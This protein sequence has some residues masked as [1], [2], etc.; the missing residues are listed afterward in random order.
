M[1]LNNN[2]LLAVQSPYV[3]QSYLHIPQ[4]PNQRGRM[5]F[6]NSS[7]TLLASLLLLKF[8]F[9]KYT[10]KA[11]L[12]SNNL[13]DGEA[14]PCIDDRICYNTDVYR[15]LIEQTIFTRAYA[16]L[17][18]KDRL[19]SLIRNMGYWAAGLAFLVTPNSTTELLIGRK[20]EALQKGE[21]TVVAIE[22]PEKI[23]VGLDE[24]AEDRDD[25][26]LWRLSRGELRE[27]DKYYR[28][29]SKNGVIY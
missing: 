21:I 13:L 15:P 24:G 14:F 28:A 7:I 27:Y 19:I 9:S 20:W 18:R 11:F 1:A 22:K 4:S 25:T 3:L 2:I 17:R 12:M 23:D 29:R 10:R 5:A 8:F 6:S 16:V 26:T